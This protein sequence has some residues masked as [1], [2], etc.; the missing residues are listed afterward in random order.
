[1]FDGDFDVALFDNVVKAFYRGSNPVERKQAE[2]ALNEFK[3]HPEAWLKADQILEKSSETESK[4]EYD[5]P[6]SQRPWPPLPSLFVSC[7]G[8]CGDVCRV[9]P[10]SRWR[11][12]PL[13]GD[14]DSR[15]HKSGLVGTNPP[16]CV[17]PQNCPADLSAVL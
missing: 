12:R 4:C 6:A 10:S 9:G 17:P 14:V 16:F 2:H 11:H 5:D 13:R 1:M 3:A 15:T 8:P 7:N